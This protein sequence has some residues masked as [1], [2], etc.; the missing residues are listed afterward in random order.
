MR[1]MSKRLEQIVF[2]PVL[3]IPKGHRRTKDD[4]W[5]L[6]QMVNVRVLILAD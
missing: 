1:F 2:L 4:D 3:M 6:I 5:F